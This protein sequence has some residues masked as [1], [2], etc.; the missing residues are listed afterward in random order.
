MAFVFDYRK[1]VT[2]YLSVCGM[3]DLYIT[4][5]PATVASSDGRVGRACASGAADSSLISSRVNQRI[6]IGIYSSPA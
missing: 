6:I 4:T 3:H 5:V 2:C 1:R